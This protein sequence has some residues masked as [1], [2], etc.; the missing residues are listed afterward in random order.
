MFSVRLS[1]Y[2]CVCQLFMAAWKLNYSY[3]CQLVDYSDNPD[4]MRVS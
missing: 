4:E 2:V 1:V 3:S